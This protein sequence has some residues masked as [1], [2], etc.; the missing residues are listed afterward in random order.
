MIDLLEHEISLKGEKE[1]SRR[2]ML[3]AGRMNLTMCL[4]KSGDWIEARDLCEKVSALWKVTFECVSSIF[5][6][7]SRIV[8]SIDKFQVLAEN[9]NVPKAYFRRGEANIQLNDLD[10]AIEDFK[11]K[12]K[13]HAQVWPL[14]KEINLTIKVISAMR[15]Q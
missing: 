2:T 9:E 1:E 13:I 7:L 11:V 4:L 14:F 12:K 3:Q 6:H 8:T 5:L 15:S 10:A